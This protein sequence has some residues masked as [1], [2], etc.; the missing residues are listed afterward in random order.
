MIFMSNVELPKLTIIFTV[1][2]LAQSSAV[3][4]NAKA[5]K[6][7]I[8]H[9]HPMGNCISSPT[10]APNRRHH[11]ISK[12]KRNIFFKFLKIWEGKQVHSCFFLYSHHFLPMF[13][14][15]GQGQHRMLRGTHDDLHVFSGQL[16][17]S[18]SDWV[19][20]RDDVWER[21]C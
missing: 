8:Y 4:I 15:E 2:F 7:T 16:Q 13:F 5:A 21:P 12:K 14:L 20:Q 6:T 17:L 9:L 3:L 19:S 18:L 11:K 1:P 10:L